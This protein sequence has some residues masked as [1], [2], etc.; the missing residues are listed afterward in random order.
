MRA[1]V[2]DIYSV[3]AKRRITKVKEQDKFEKSNLFEGMV[4]LRSLLAAYE[5]DTN[6]RKILQVLYDK[7]KVKKNPKERMFLQKRGE[8]LGF[9]VQDVDKNEIDALADP[10]ICGNWIV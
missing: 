9:T 8:T 5:S 2:R 3:Y 6:D 4:S 10:E 1:F 7:E